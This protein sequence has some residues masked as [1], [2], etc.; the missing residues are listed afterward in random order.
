MCVGGRGGNKVEGR[1][2]RKGEVCRKKENRG[3]VVDEVV[4]KERRKCGMRKEM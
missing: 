4:L 1:R 2:G 3:K